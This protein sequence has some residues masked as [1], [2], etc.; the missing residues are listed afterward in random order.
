MAF[1]GM[2]AKFAGGMGGGGGQLARLGASLK[3]LDGGAARA[4]QKV[5]QLARF[6][7]KDLGATA[8]GAMGAMGKLSGALTGGLIAPLNMVQDMVGQIAQ[9]VN[10]AN[11]GAFVQFTM[12]M[13]NWM[14]ILGRTM[15]PMLQGITQY[16]RIAGDTFA[17]LEPVLRPLFQTIGDYFVGLAQTA[18]PLL[19]AAA[20]FIQLFVDAL[21]QFVKAFGKVVAFVQGAITALLTTLASALGLQSRF[22]PSK[23]AM[24]AA[25]HSVRMSSVDEMA[26]NNFTRQAE[27][28]M[29]LGDQK[30]DTEYLKEI[31]AAAE[32]GKQMMTDLTQ[33]IKD[34]V[35][36]LK[37]GREAAKDA[38]KN[39]QE[40]GGGAGLGAI[41]G[42]WMVS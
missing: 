25:V 22:D 35:E 28:A 33:A 13:S 24:G 27:A 42:R 19:Q 3:D 40:G 14:A 41:M 23:N 1:A 5:N 38:K 6:G 4:G 12:A 36:W 37:N 2:L 7:L 39:V 20:P 16:A 17:K 9:L 15:Q 32:R 11:P 31:A 21:S 29:G 34:L 26:R 8:L 18:G 10:L 30:T